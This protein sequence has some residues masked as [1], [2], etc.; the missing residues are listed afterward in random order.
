MPPFKRRWASDISSFPTVLIFDFALDFNV[1]ES[2][3]FSD[4]SEAIVIKRPSTSTFARARL[5]QVRHC[6]GLGRS[7]LWVYLP[8][9]TGS[10]REDGIASACTWQGS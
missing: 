5:H 10:H 9:S 4:P 1:V 8:H 3:P 6:C 7:V 2:C